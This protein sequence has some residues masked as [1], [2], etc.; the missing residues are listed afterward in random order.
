ML[1]GINPI[2]A[3][4]QRIGAA[5][6]VFVFTFACCGIGALMAFVIS[7]QQAVEWRRIQ[8][9]PQIDAVTYQSLA[10]GEEAV[11]TGT[12]TDNPEL[13]EGFVAYRVDEW[14]IEETTNS[15]GTPEVDGEWQRVETTIPALTLS[16]DGGTVRTTPVDNARFGGSTGE[17]IEESDATRQIDNIPE[18]SLRTQGYANDDLITIVG[19]KASTGDFVPDRFFGGDRVEL[20]ENIRTG[21]RA[22]FFIGIAMMVAAPFV[23]VFGLFQAVFGRAQRG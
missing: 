2:E 10:T 6:G 13:R 15:E 12:L 5:I 16:I 23:L 3:I 18:G 7:P 20:V 1:R 14:A 9:A 4:R 22:A 11:I 21:A 19:Q 8:N 17:V